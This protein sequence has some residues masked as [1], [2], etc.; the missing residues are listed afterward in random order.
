MTE[1]R[2]CPGEK[3]EAILREGQFI[4]PTC[5]EKLEEEDRKANVHNRK[6]WIKSLDKT[7]GFMGGR[8][9]RCK[10]DALETLKLYPLPELSEGDRRRVKRSIITETR[11]SISHGVKLSVVYCGNCATTLEKHPDRE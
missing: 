5:A 3:C 7:I 9:E 11:K 1:P 4:C 6:A 10:S 8:C 2:Q